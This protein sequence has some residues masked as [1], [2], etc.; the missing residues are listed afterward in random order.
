LAEIEGAYSGGLGPATSAFGRMP[1]VVRQIVAPVSKDLFPLDVSTSVLDDRLIRRPVK[2][3]RR[4]V[5]PAW[6]GFQEG[7][8]GLE[9]GS[10]VREARTIDSGF[11][12]AVFLLRK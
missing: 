9:N 11:N 6:S 4:N 5:N 2:D 10:W 7:E 8:F 1:A 3:A 12:V